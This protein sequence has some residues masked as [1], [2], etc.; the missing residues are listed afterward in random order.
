MRSRR[1]LFACVN[2]H[3]LP[4]G[5]GCRRELILALVRLDN[6]KVEGVDAHW[7]VNLLRRLSR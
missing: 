1:E 2:D 3:V 6:E 5:A 4:T 7:G